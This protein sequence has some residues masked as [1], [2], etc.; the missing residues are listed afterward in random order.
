MTPKQI[1]KHLKQW[2]EL[3]KSK[4]D[5]YYNNYRGLVEHTQSKELW[6][7]DKL[8]LDEVCEELNYLNIK[9]VVLK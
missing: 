4:K 3:R 9:E 7:N 6:D 2:H 5:G 8:F 1:S